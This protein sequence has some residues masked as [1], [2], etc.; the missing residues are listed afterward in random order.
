MK[1]KLSYCLNVRQILGV[2]NDISI[3]L[4]SI[5]MISI[6]NHLSLGVCFGIYSFAYFFWL[7]LVAAF[8]FF[9]IHVRLLR[10]NKRVSQS[11]SQSTKRSKVKVTGRQKPSQQSGVMFTYD[12]LIE[13]R[14]WVGCG[15]E[16]P[17]V[18]QPIASSSSSSSYF[19]WINNSNTWIL[20]DKQVARKS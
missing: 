17:S 11:V 1:R 18:T 13:R 19:I 8:S 12:L 7:C 10:V 14:L 16:F 5:N 3:N 20:A 6:G 2:I 15:L 4:H 9:F